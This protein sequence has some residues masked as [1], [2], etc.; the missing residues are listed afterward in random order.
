VSLEV[1]VRLLQERRPGARIVVAGLTS[2]LYGVRQLTTAQICWLSLAPLWR[3][4]PLYRRR[5]LEFLHRCL[6]VARM[7]LLTG[8]SAER[9]HNQ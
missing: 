1:M 8:S 9:A 5:P 2:A 4:N 3:H 7:A 6:R